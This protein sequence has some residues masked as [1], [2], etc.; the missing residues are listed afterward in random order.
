M[1][2]PTKNE[3]KLVDI[4]FQC[5]ATATDPRYPA[6]ARMTMEE[7]MAW[8]ATQLNECGFQNTPVGASWGYLTRSP[9]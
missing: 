2:E 1:A 7:R 9:D 5:V 8:A 4:L 3:R 6:F